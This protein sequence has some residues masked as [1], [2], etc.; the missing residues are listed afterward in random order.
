MSS[1]LTTRTGWVDACKGFTITAV[2]FH[3]VVSQQAPGSEFYLERWMDWDLQLSLLRLPLFFLVA[4]LFAGRAL[5]K[6]WP[7]F[8]ERK[9]L[10]FAYLFT[11]WS[12]LLYLVRVLMPYLVFGAKSG[13]LGSIFWI[14]I[15][16]PQTLWFIYA[17]MWMFLLVRLLRHRPRWLWALAA[18]GYL[19]S[20]RE[21]DL[22]PS[23][24]P[25]NFFRFLPFFLAGLFGSAFWFRMARRWHWAAL[26]LV[27][28]FL[29][30]TTQIPIHYGISN[31]PGLFIC[32]VVGVGAGLSFV[33]A[34]DRLW[35]D[36][37][38]R[39]IGEHSLAIYL[40]HR[41][42]LEIFV[43]M[44]RL[45]WLSPSMAM[46]NILVATLCAVAIPMLI[47]V[48]IQ[49]RGWSGWLDLPTRFRKRV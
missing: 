7:E 30:L 29:L 26:T 2:V 21:G 1:A 46:V 4:G 32:H 8:F 48:W 49:R 38:W 20:S 31:L 10:H 33:L 28:L 17:L 40:M 16:P 36:S 41:L 22:M 23:S 34:W 42:V 5:T 45:R 37:L 14:F 9:V 35:P 6:T 13:R 27:P 18:L 24:F 25:I 44:Q 15:R 19:W 47:S 12:T 11:L 3:H 43:N 39:R